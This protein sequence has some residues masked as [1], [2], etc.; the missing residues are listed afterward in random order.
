MQIQIAGM[1]VDGLA[2]SVRVSG[3]D[4]GSARALELSLLHTKEHPCPP[5]PVGS[6][7]EAELDGQRFSGV[8]FRRSKA[9]DGN[10]LSLLCYDRGI[11]LNKNQTTERFDSVTPEAAGAYL[12]G[13]FGIP[14]GQFA[15]TGIRITR[16]FF[17]QSIYRILM[18]LYTI[19]ARQN[20][21]A[22][23]MRFDGAAC[24]VIEK[25]TG[26]PI[27]LS[28]RLTAAATVESIERVVNAVAIYDRDGNLL[29]M[30]EDAE[31]IAAYGRMQAVLRDAV[32]RDLA[33]EAEGML[34]SEVS[35]TITVSGMGDARCITGGTVQLTEPVTGL[36]GVFH[37]A[38]DSHE[39]KNGVYHCRLTLDFKAIQNE[40]QVGEEENQ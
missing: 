16:K 3:N 29:T 11:Y 27:R 1:A 24:S 14:V 13:K 39:W 38:E 25:G 18:D 6:M 30:R 2:V 5:C 19:A 7:V 32:G 21:K 12:C 36:V 31:S 23:C 8:V 40:V 20:G 10:T 22:Y 15:P 9:A 37:I 17:G 28:G 34:E 33:A 26:A 35:Q 4:E